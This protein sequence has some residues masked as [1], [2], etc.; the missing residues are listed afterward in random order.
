[1]RL[2]PAYVLGAA[3]ALIMAVA[4]GYAFSYGNFWEEGAALVGT[5]WGIVSLIDVYVG[6]AMFAGWVIY[7]EASLPRSVILVIAICAL[8]NLIAG[9]YIIYAAASAKGD[10]A[11]FWMGRRR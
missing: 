11:T 10:V 7:R 9:L 6:F 5:T 2:L 1:M 8:G 3:C 4:L